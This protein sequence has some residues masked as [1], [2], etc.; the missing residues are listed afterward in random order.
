MAV[1]VHV[2]FSKEW[3]R[4]RMHGDA[5]TNESSAQMPSELSL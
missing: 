1:V 2:I 5:C 3:R 4:F